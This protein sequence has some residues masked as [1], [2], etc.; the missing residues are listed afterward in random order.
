MVGGVVGS[1]GM[2]CGSQL[3]RSLTKEKKDGRP[4]KKTFDVGWCQASE[5]VGSW[6]PPVCRDM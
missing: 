3:K 5:G 2:L 6:S 1:G 4:F